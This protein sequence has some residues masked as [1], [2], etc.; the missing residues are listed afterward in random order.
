MTVVVTRQL[1]TSNVAPEA[2]EATQ[3]L[4]ISPGVVGAL[5]VTVIVLLPTGRLVLEQLTFW[6]LTVQVQPAPEAA[7]FVT[8]AGRVSFTSAFDA[9]FGPALATLRVQV[10]G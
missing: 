2:P 5:P 1:L 8:P 4:V 3:V 9:G 7:M 6:P 10:I